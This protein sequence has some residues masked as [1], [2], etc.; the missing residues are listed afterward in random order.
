MCVLLL[1]RSY[2][3]GFFNFLVFI[4]P[5]VTQQQL[6]GNDDINVLQ[7]LCTAIRCIPIPPRNIWNRGVGNGAAEETSTGRGGNGA[8]GTRNISGLLRGGNGA[9]GNTAATTYGSRNISGLTG[10]TGVGNAAAA[11]NL[12]RLEPIESILSTTDISVSSKSQS[13]PNWNTVHGGIDDKN[14]EQRMHNVSGPDSLA[15]VLQH[16]TSTVNASFYSIGEVGGVE[17]QIEEEMGQEEK[18]EIEERM[19]IA[20]EEVGM[21]DT[22]VESNPVE[23]EKIKGNDDIA[24]DE[25]TAGVLKNDTALE[26]SYLR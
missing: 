4:Y 14:K 11:A 7:A 12:P 2:I 10:T 18:I 3:P 25:D 19:T 13:V 17:S 23:G 24:K 1:W 5:R 8:V 20:D 16:T 26:P 21:L 9:A 22:A 15:I 6:R